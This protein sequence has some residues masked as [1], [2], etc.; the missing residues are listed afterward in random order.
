[1]DTHYTGGFSRVTS[2]FT[3]LRHPGK[4]S[5]HIKKGASR[6]LL[7]LHSLTHLLQGKSLIML[8]SFTESYRDQ[9]P[10]Q[11]GSRLPSPQ[12]GSPFNH[13]CTGKDSNTLPRVFSKNRSS[14][15]LAKPDNTWKHVQK[16]NHDPLVFGQILFPLLF[17]SACRVCLSTSI[18]KS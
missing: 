6:K 16:M 5:L 11:V 7:L 17:P 12:I 2:L 15:I 18:M 13:R 14:K 3:F 9:N 8:Q 1:M 4:S 10:T